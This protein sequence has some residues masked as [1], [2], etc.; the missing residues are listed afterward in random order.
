M[1][2]VLGCREW[3]YNKHQSTDSSLTYWFNF[4]WI[5]SQEW[6]AGSYGRVQVLILEDSLLWFSV[7]TTHSLHPHPQYAK[8]LSPPQPVL[9]ISCPFYNSHSN[10]Q[11]SISLADWG[12]IS[13]MTSDVDHVLHLSGVLSC[14]S[15][16]EVSIYAHYPLPKI[17]ILIF[18]LL[19][20][21][22]FYVFWFCL[23]YV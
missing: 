1:F 11:S 12:C 9:A 5:N 18:L 10:F 6:I 19:D 23:M 8:I 2:S 4:L 15:S 3:Y 14:V 21:L 7:M 17:I 20:L 13:L 22:C 16:S